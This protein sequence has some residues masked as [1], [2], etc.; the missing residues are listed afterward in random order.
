[1][2]FLARVQ[3]PEIA[4]IVGNEG[5]V[6]GDDARHQIPIGLSAQSKPVDVS[7]LMAARL[8][9]RDK[10]GVQT[11]VDEKL[12]AG[13]RAFVEGRGSPFNNVRLDDLTLRPRSESFFGRPRVG[14]AAVHILASSIMRAVRLG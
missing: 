13:T 11:L 6:L 7:G 2:Q 10:E 5:E 8:R 3:L 1:M 14:C 12:H 9:D 4:S